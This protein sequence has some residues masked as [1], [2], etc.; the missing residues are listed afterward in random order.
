MDAL[1]TL[2]NSMVFLFLLSYCKMM[3]DYGHFIAVD[4][5]LLFIYCFYV[6]WHRQARRRVDVYEKFLRMTSCLQ[7]R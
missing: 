3:H 4:S 2:T 6:I 7:P 1:I 5:L